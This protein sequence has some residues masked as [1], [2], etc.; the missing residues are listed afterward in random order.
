M[1]V[2][3]FSDVAARLLHT[4]LHSICRFARLSIAKTRTIE[5]KEAWNCLSLDVK[6]S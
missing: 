1:Q 5:C 2:S 6:E 4:S 3:P